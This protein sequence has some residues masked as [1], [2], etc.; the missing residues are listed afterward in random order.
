[1]LDQL[2]AALR[3]DLS[4]VVFFWNDLSD[5]LTRNAPAFQLDQAGFVQR[6]DL[7]IAADFDPLASRVA[8]SIDENARVLQTSFLKRLYKGG[9]RGLRYRLFGIRPRLPTNSQEYEAGWILTKNYLAMLSRRAEEFGSDFVVISIPGQSRVD[10]GAR[11]AGIE[12]LAFEIEEKLASVCA[13]LNIPY[14][15]LLPDISAAHELSESPL[16]YFADRHLTPLGN[17]VVA[18]ALSGKLATLVSE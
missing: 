15:D 6:T 18:N 11:I 5:N 14:I 16:Y 4:V 8:V 17:G 9:I 3:P 13:E 1:V 12:P 7:E 2:G 10:P